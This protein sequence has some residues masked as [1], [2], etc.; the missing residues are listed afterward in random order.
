MLVVWC[1]DA[2]SDRDVLQTRCSGNVY[3]LIFV[4]RVFGLSLYTVH[5]ADHT[6]AAAVVVY[7]V[8][9]IFEWVSVFNVWAASNEHFDHWNLCYEFPVN[10]RNLWDFGGVFLLL[11]G[12]MRHYYQTDHNNICTHRQIDGQTKSFMKLFISIW[13]YQQIWYWIN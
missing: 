7:F 10:K 6:A 4:C 11:C 2:R 3:Y 9:Y 12:G 5:P 1:T 13:F 8:T